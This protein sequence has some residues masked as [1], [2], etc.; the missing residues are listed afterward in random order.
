VCFSVNRLDPRVLHRKYRQ[1][2][3]V[4]DRKSVWLKAGFAAQLYENTGNTSIYD[5]TPANIP[6]VLNELHLAYGQAHD[7]YDQTHMPY[8]QT[9]GLQPS[10]IPSKQM[11]A[12][13]LAVH[14]YASARGIWS[15]F[16]VWYNSGYGWW[17][18][19]YQ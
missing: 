10:V 2:K 19:V 3:R 8:D 14:V 15:G 17:L 13:R 7:I 18:C 4:L 11:R 9:H 6:P 1:A 5:Q 16:M 12:L